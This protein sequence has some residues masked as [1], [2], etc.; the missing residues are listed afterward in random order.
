MTDQ[1]EMGHDQQK[2]DSHEEQSNLYDQLAERARELFAAGRDK[3]SEALESAVET[4]RKQLTE[5]GTFSAE[6][7]KALKEY[8]LKDMNRLATYS[9]D[10]GEEAKEKLEPSR[11]GAGALSSL[12]S[13]L[14]LAGDAFLGLAAKTD[15]ALSCRTGEITTAGSLTCKQCGKTIHLKKSGHIPPCPQCSG[16]QFKKG[17]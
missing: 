2:K 12:S 8:L 4:A 5:A 16:T 10:L 13:L 14:H 7:G 6:K 15:Q 9:R 11:L 17:Y 1:Q 3:T